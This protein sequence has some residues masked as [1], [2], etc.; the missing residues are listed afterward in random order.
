ML[1]RSTR[2][3]EAITSA[4]AIVRGIAPDGGLYVPESLP[5][6]EEDEVR[7]LGRELGLPERIVMRQPF[8]G[9]GLAVRVIGEITPEKL[10]LVRE[11]DAI[12]REVLETSGFS[13][14]VN[15]YFAVLTNMETVGV[16]GDERSYQ[17][18]VALRAV[19]TE[20]FMTADFAR[21]PYELLEEASRR[22]VNE[23]PGINR[24]VY[25]ITS[26]PPATVEF[27]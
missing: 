10:A 22:I 5:F 2:G 15:Q 26:K 23:V 13:S 12:F 21:I 20:D 16:M 6:L 19:C 17:Y 9:P 11:A 3:G 4:Q 25:D 27:E 8:P 24:V 18:A 7:A 1:Y 14:E